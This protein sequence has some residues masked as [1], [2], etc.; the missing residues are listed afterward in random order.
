MNPEIIERDD[1]DPDDWIT[2]TSYTE[3]RV[4]IYRNPAIW[5]EIQ[6]L[7]QQIQAAEQ[8]VVDLEAA[9]TPPQQ[10][11]TDE[12]SLAEAAAPIA[13]PAGEESLGDVAVVESETLAAAR[14]ELDRLIA[15]A[16]EAYARYEA[17]TEVW[18]LRALDEDEMRECIRLA[19]IEQPVEPMRFSRDA[20]KATR[21]KY[22]AAADTYAREMKAWAEAVNI[23]CIQKACRGVV[24]AGVEKPTPSVESMQLLAKRP[25]GTMH[26]K[27]L[28]DALASI[29]AREVE[30]AAPKSLT[31]SPA[32]RRSS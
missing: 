19:G 31:A 10:E 32:A 4:N 21:R 30:I 14:G 18:T 9:A 17:D 5:A 20:S 7:Y 15:I 8:T 16:E 12:S 6:P 27:R 13:V 23:L 1:V 2:G 26:I 22:F 25:G 24:V 3:C 28:S 11:Q 29:S